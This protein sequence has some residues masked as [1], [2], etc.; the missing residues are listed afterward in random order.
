M[1]KYYFKISENNECFEDCKITKS[2]FVEN[3]FVKIGSVVCTNCSKNKG[4]G[5]DGD[6]KYI[7]CKVLKD[8]LGK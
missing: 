5:I 2:M 4:Y 3:S 6:K 7:K 8:A 1:E